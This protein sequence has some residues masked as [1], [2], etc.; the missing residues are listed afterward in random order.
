MGAVNAWSYSRLI[1]YERCPFQFKLSAIDRIKELPSAAMER[2]KTIHKQAEDFL[3]GKDP[4]PPPVAPVLLELYDAMRDYR[5]KLVEGELALTNKWRAT[6]WFA[7]DC[8]LRVKFDVVLLYPDDTAEV[9]DHKTGKPYGDNT[10]QM[11][12]YATALMSER[13]TLKS[14]RVRL[15]YVD[16]GDQTYATV[17]RGNLQQYQRK[18]E[19]RVAP[20]LA[21]TQFA[22]R[23][24][25]HCRFCS[26]SRSTGGQCSFG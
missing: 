13:K 11:N 14:V 24:G 25:S 20:M 21:D 16:S 12:L 10:D 18:W 7:S 2:G 5:P 1:K 26:Y 8:W 23:P 9:C 6:G 22:P 15:A 17:E 4:L 19:D 3:S